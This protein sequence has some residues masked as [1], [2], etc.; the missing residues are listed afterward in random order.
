LLLHLGDLRKHVVFA[1]RLAGAQAAA[2]R[3]FSSSARSSPQS[4]GTPA[5]CRP[6]RYVASSSA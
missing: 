3:A 6:A 4:P 2:R 1:A 5:R